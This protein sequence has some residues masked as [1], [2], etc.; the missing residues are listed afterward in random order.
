[1]ENITMYGYFARG[2]TKQEALFTATET[3]MLAKLKIQYHHEVR[4]TYPGT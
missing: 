2:T 4:I 1:M 3:L